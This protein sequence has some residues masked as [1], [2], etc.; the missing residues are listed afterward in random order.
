MPKPEDERRRRAE[1]RRERSG[2]PW[3]PNPR[4]PL[5]PELADFLKDKEIACLFQATTGE[6]VLVVKAPAAEIQSVRGRVPIALRHEL[7]DHPASPEIRT[8]L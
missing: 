2:A 4:I 7:Y 6:T 1:R 8:V 5:V 3:E